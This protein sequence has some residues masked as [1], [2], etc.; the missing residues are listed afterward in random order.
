MSDIAT[1]VIV[2]GTLNTLIGASVVTWSLILIKGIQHL[3]IGFHNRKFSK[4]FWSSPNIQAAAQ[5][6]DLKGP[7]AR[8]AG[9]GFST[10]IETDD[11][12]STH[13]LEHTWDRQELLDRR[14]RQQMQKE[15]GS[16]E[17]GLAV[18]ATIGSISPFVGLFGTVWGIMGALTSISKSGSASL[19]VVAGPIG[20][21]LIATAVGIAVAV[22]AVVGYNFFIRRNKVIWAFLDDFAIDFVHLALKASFIIERP[23]GKSQT[24]PNLKGISGKKGT[25]FVESSDDL[26]AQEAHA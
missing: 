11:G 14:L 13:D 20:E 21:A 1:S 19:E 2:D 8:V 22:P 18:L 7:A 12:A 5:L 15:R 6:E 17:S 25:P 23:K 4:A 16:L 3:R 10:L 9:A 26:I 24:Q